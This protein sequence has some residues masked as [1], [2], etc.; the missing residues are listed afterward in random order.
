MR[1]LIQAGPMALLLLIALYTKI[2]HKAWTENDG[3]LS[4][5]LMMF[6]LFGLCESGFNNPYLNFT[7]VLAAK[8]LLYTED[9]EAP[10]GALHLAPNV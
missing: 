3:L 7:L 2:M 6:I 9:S 8:E 4:L 1:I 10:Q 5:I